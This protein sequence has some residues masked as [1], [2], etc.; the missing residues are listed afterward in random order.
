M[1]NGDNTVRQL[2]GEAFDAVALAADDDCHVAGEVGFVDRFA[3]HCGAENVNAAILKLAYGVVDVGYL[4]HVDVFGCAGGN[5]DH[6]F[7][8]AHR[9]PL[10][11]D[12]SVRAH[13]LGR[14]D[15]AS[16]IVR[17]GYPVQN[18]HEQRFAFF[19]CKVVNVV[20]GR[21][22]EFRRVC[23]YALM[24]A[25]RAELVQSVLACENRRHLC[26]F[27][28]L[29]DAVH[30]GFEIAFHDVKFF[31]GFAGRKRFGD[32]VFPFDDHFYSSFSYPIFIISES[33]RVLP[34][35][36]RYPITASKPVAFL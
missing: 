33:L 22:F 1:R 19:L 15:Y 24:L 20:H 6:R 28:H 4:H 3:V 23:H 35:R 8:Y 7:A 34:V 5:L 21:I 13:A 36:Y 26:G 32:G 17:V 9:A 16:Q 12:N 31:N 14:T 30:G 2:L 11:N 29:H 25:G 10:R 18:H 27:R